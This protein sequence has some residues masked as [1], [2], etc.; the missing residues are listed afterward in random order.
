[1]T[2][3]QGEQEPDCLRIASGG[4][5]DDPSHYG[6]PHRDGAA[7]PVLI[8]HNAGVERS[9]QNSTKILNLLGPTMRIAALPRLE[10]CGDRRLPVPNG[11]AVAGRG[12]ASVPTHDAPRIG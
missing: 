12:G 3:Q 4:V 7:P 11:V 8:N 2:M 5:V 6:F 9:I 1:M 10:A